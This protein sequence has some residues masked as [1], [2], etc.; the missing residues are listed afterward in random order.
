MREWRSDLRAAVRNGDSGYWNGSGCARI[1]CRTS[2]GKTQQKGSKETEG[3]G[4]SIGW[5]G[6]GVAGVGAVFGETP[7]FAVRHHSI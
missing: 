5:P 2:G 1:L 4:T 6:D 7:V 3:P